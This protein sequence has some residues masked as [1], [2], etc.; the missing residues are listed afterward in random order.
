MSKDSVRESGEHRGLNCPEPLKIE[1]INK[2]LLQ[3]VSCGVHARPITYGSARLCDQVLLRPLEVRAIAQH[4]KPVARLSLPSLHRI[5]GGPTPRIIIRVATA[6]YFH[7]V[8]GLQ[9]RPQTMKCW[10]ED[11]NCDPRAYP[12]SWV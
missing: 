9:A 3:L 6:Q 10:L 8:I 5:L 1:A 4:S 11:T 2:R 12:T 7:I